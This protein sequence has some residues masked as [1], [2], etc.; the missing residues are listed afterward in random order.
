MRLR[1]IV[2]I[3]LLLVPVELSAQRIPRLRGR[4][5]ARPTTLPPQAPEIAREM[6]YKRLRVSFESYPLLSYYD[7]SGLTN[8]TVS[9]WSSLGTGARA[10]YRLKPHLSVTFDVTSSFYGGP[11]VTE[12]A[13]LGLRFGSERG[14]KRL[15]PFADAR[16]GYLYAHNTYFRPLDITLDGASQPVGFGGRYSN[17][18]GA[19]GG[20]G[21]EYALTRRFSLITG[22][23]LLRARMTAHGFHDP[24]EPETKYW[25]TSQRYTIGLRFN[26][27]RVIRMPGTD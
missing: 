16:I 10:D 7:A 19:I 21:F 17:G 8:G 9:S 3:V 24:D 27:V 14:D 12:T 23:S 13:E 6:S 2:A 11:A 25:L 18:F 22:I 15:Y 5:P 4:G 26:P 20:G 1:A